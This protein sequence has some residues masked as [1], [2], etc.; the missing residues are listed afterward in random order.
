M[1]RILIDL[2]EFETA[3]DKEET[4]AQMHGKNSAYVKGI[5]AAKKIALS[6]KDENENVPIKPEKGGIPIAST[7]WYMCGNCK[8]GLNPG[9]KY[10]HECG[11]AIDW[12]VEL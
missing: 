10:C 12:N 2:V 7:W 6:C 5:R 4:F 11:R 9:D 1:S 8:T 3:L